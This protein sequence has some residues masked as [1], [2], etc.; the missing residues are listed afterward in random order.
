MDTISYADI[1]HSHLFIVKKRFINEAA[2]FQVGTY[3]SMY[4]IKNKNITCFQV[5]DQVPNFPVSIDVHLININAV[6]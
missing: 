1:I 3:K 5:S 4:K 2:D 6:L